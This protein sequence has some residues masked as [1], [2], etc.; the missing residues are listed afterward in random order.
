MMCYP[1]IRLSPAI[2]G[3]CV[4]ATSRS[5]G[6]R[7]CTLKPYENPEPFPGAAGYAAQLVMLCVDTELGPVSVMFS[8]VMLRVLGRHL[9][10]L[11]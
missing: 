3:P 5:P 4:S 1:R 7:R 10:Y 9:G 8:A 11:G 6:R 2:K